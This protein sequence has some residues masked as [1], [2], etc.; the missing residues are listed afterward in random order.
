MKMS[1]KQ[2]EE[3]VA[4][5]IISAQ[6]ARDLQQFLATSPSMSATFSFTHV[7]YYVGGLLAIGAMTL[8]MNLGWESFG[9]AGMVGLCVIYALLGLVLTEYWRARGLTVPAGI[10]ATFVVCLTP[11]AIYGL[12]LWLGVWPDDS[13][14]R[15]Y[16]RYVKWH[17]LYMELGTLMVGVVMAWRYKYPFLVLPLAFTLWYLTMDITAMISGG[18]FNWELRQ[19]VSLYTGLA[20]T[21]L[22]IWVDIRS[23]QKAD[24]AFWIYLFGV[25]AFWG[26]LSTQSSDSEL[27]KFGYFCINLLMIVVG[28]VLV[29]RIFVVLGALGCC[30][31]IGYLAW[32]L[33]ANSWLFPIMLTVIG[34][35]V[36][37]LGILWQRHERS[38]TQKMHAYLPAAW[39]AFLQSKA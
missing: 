14:Y 15:D 8:F 19:L 25:M 35:S 37:Y 13:V 11:L 31:Y 20:M 34:L 1:K 10:A 16:H 7:L 29:R 2:L 23:R 38:L 30:G 18:D 36:V 12:Q 33:F 39:R 17:W 5:R 6:Q 28:V 22:A 24:Y 21:A 4:A 32:D 26:G 9:G 3:A 27:A